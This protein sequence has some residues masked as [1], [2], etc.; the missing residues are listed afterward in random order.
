[1]NITLSSRVGQNRIEIGIHATGGI[2]RRISTTGKVVSNEA[3]CNAS[4]NPI[5]TPTTC[6]SRNPDVMRL[7]LSSQPF[8]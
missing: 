4:S 2:G 3:L 6:A 7:T 8:Q 1:M 5:G